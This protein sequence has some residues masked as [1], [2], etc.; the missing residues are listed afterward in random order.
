MQPHI[1][2]DRLEGVKHGVAVSYKDNTCHPRIVAM[3]LYKVIQ[4]A[5]IKPSL[6]SV[7]KG[8]ALSFFLFF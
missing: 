1:V 6:H 3:E 2:R 5:S 8:G 4:G 7:L